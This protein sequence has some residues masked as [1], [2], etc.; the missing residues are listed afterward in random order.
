[1]RILSA[2]FPAL[3]APRAANETRPHETCLRRENSARV[4]SA[5]ALERVIGRSP[6]SHDSASIEHESR[7]LFKRP[8]SLDV[9]SWRMARAD[10]REEY[11][12]IDSCDQARAALG[13]RSLDRARHLLTESGGVTT[14][15]RGSFVL[16]TLVRRA[17]VSFWQNSRPRSAR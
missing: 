12:V 5:H 11:G 15:T 7:A 3:S 2:R 9:V 14:A 13:D 16:R 4:R 17:L 10:S 8:E 1:K 6:V